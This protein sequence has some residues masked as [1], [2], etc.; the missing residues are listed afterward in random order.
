MLKIQILILIF[1]QCFNQKTNTY[2]IRKTMSILFKMLRFSLN[3]ILIKNKIVKIQIQN[4]RN[5]QFKVQIKKSKRVN[6]KTKKMKII[7]KIIITDKYID[8]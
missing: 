7:Y 4:R 3:S 5:H 1:H 2:R 6:S 8:Y